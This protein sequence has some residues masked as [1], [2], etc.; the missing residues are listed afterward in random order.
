MKI[1]ITLFSL[2]S[3]I[4]LNAAQVAKVLTEEQKKAV[5]DVFQLIY[6]NKL[7]DLKK[8][9]QDYPE[10]VNEIPC[11]FV[12]KE[13]EAYC[14]EANSLSAL[15]Y[16]I[17]IK[18]HEALCILLEYNA[19]PDIQCGYDKE[20]ALM[21]AAYREAWNCVKTLIEFGVDKEFK[22]KNQKNALYAAEHNASL[23]SRQ[24]NY[25]EAMERY[26]QA[27]ADGEAERDRYA[28]EK[29]ISL[30]V[31]QSFVT[32]KDL[33]AIVCGYAYGVLPRDLPKSDK[34]VI[35]QTGCLPSHCTI[36]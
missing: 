21:W 2:A 36:Q 7:D 32:V 9:L 27:I 1:L 24:S 25:E 23:Y 11:A 13:G 8:N 6:D 14:W 22:N 31:V 20:T 28:Q 3:C 19:N 30:E 33:A 35:K 5:Q 10:I 34:K 18:K 26:H 15:H 4:T 17:K 16:A 29:Q 12:W